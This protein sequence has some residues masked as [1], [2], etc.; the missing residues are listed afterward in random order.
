MH[1]LD[2]IFPYR[3]KA[4]FWS[5]FPA[6]SVSGVNY[7]NSIA[8]F[9][10]LRLL[11]QKI[12]DSIFGM[13]FYVL[14]H[15]LYVRCTY[16]HRYSIMSKTRLFCIATLWLACRSMADARSRESGFTGVKIKPN[17]PLAWG[18]S[19]PEKLLVPKI[20]H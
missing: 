8:C 6:S 18:M 19:S 9:V 2:R 15:W 7:V 16:L 4:S 10:I 5:T 3:T 11:Y 1:A 20:N 17:F 12:V 14:P 13:P